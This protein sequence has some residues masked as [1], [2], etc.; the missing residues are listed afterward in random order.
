M[1]EDATISANWIVSLIRDFIAT[2]PQN[3]MQDGTGK[4]AWDL[5]LVGFAS[6]ADQIWQQYKE[7]VGAFHWTPWEVFNQHCRH[8]SLSWPASLR[9]GARPC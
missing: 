6:G 9:A 2:S 8:F 1:E 5:T 4:P 3:S 7:Y